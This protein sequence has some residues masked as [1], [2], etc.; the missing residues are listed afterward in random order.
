MSNP[1]LKE[2]GGY[3]LGSTEVHMPKDPNALKKIMEKAKAK[4]VKIHL[5]VDGVCAQSYSP[6]AKTIIC[7]NA[8]V[9]DGW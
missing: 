5:P 8:D 2:F 6:D 1:F 3:K 4:N 9:P 7:D